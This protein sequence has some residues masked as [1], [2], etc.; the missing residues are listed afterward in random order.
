M[1]IILPETIKARGEWLKAARPDQIP[2]ENL[3]DWLYYLIL[4]GRGWGKTRTSAEDCAWYAQTHPGEI[5]HVVCPTDSDVRGVYFEGPSGLL[6]CLPRASIAKAL[7]SPYY[8]VTLINGTIIKGFSAEK[9]DRLRGPQCHRAYADELA[10]WRVPKVKGKEADG[11]HSNAWDQLLFGLRLGSNPRVVITTTPRPTALVRR[12]LEDPMTLVIRGSTFQNRLNLAPAALEQLKKRYDGTRLGRQELYGEVL[13]DVVGALWTRAMLDAANAPVKIPDF[14]RIV[15]AVDPS[16]VRDQNDTGSDEVGIVAV[17][18]GVD[19]RGYVLAD[20]SCRMSPLG[21]GTRAIQLYKALGAD[22]IVAERN[23][24]GAM[25]EYTIKSIDPNVAY[26]EV[27]ASH[28]KIQR[29]EPIA[30]MYEKSPIEVSHVAEDMLRRQGVNDV[31]SGLLST[32]EN[33]MCGM[34]STGYLG[35][36]SP[37]RVDALVWGLTELFLSENFHG[38]LGFYRGEHDAMKARQEEER[39]RQEAIANGDVSAWFPK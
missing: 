39:K 21:W 15:V 20:W 9:P 34:T 3:S 11:A 27:V 28:G 19:G 7:K 18:K 4:S 12:I 33:Q 2:P 6:A 16:G 5:I 17:A 36:G 26:K 30:A 22:R 8:E 14:Q 24:G 29:A 32:L 38:F 31:P 10:A 23:F 13:D 35:D 37:D 25:V 1:S